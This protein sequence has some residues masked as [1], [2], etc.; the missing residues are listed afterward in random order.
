M[1]WRALL[2][3]LFFLLNNGIII[4]EGIP[5]SQSG[6]IRSD[7][8]PEIT[9]D[10]NMQLMGEGV[11]QFFSD[12][13]SGQLEYVTSFL[14]NDFLDIIVEDGYAFCAVTYGL[15][16]LD[17]AGGLPFDTLS[18]LYLPSRYG[19][20]GDIEKNGDILYFSRYYDGVYLVDVSN[21]EEPQILSQYPARFRITYSFAEDNLLF[22][23]DEDSSLTILDVTDPSQPELLSTI[24]NLGRVKRVCANDEIALVA[25]GYQLHILKTIDPS[26]PELITSYE[27][28]GGKYAT[29]V[30]LDGNIAY[31]SHGVYLPGIAMLILDI[32]NPSNPELISIYEPSDLDVWDIDMVLQ[33]TIIFF[34]SDIVDVRD[35]RTPHFIYQYRN[36]TGTGID[37]YDERIYVSRHTLINV[38]DLGP[39]QDTPEM[40]NSLYVGCHFLSGYPRS[41]LDGD[42]II[43]DSLIY[44]SAS[45][46]GILSVNVNDVENP[47]IIGCLE[48]QYYKELFDIQ[49]DI[50]YADKYIIDINNPA[51]MKVVGVFSDLPFLS[52]VID[53]YIYDSFAF[54]VIDDNLNEDGL[55]L[56][57]V[58]D[59]TT[60]I[61]IS[62]YEASSSEEKSVIV[63]DTIAYLTTGS[64]LHI[65]DYSNAATPQLISIYGDSPYASLA[66]S[67]S[68]AYLATHKKFE[69]VDISDPA[70]PIQLGIL[71]PPTY[72]YLGT[73]R[74]IALSGNYA[75][76][77]TRYT[78][79]QAIDISN[80]LNPFLAETYRTPSE[81]SHDICIRDN[82]IY[83]AD[84]YGLMVLN[85]ISKI[86]YLC[87][88]INADGTVNV[89]DAVNLMSYIFTHGPAPEPIERGELNC[90][91]EINVSDIIHLINFIFTKGNGPCDTDGD[92]IPDC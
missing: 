86:D 6:N 80:P 24:K 29:N 7:E 84:V 37:V 20:T 44:V 17:V 61:F 32:S 9:V 55:Y 8:N 88:D 28:P 45:G 51:D 59:P 39:L 72:P 47:K 43:H 33:D 52:D 10:P 82:L 50:L 75:Y 11:Q 15:I 31:V 49:N 77:A 81:G 41:V 66:I 46:Q 38:Y 69:V 63:I 70:L 22:M 4:A 48:Y 68:I 92:G 27:L 87:G 2:M 74:G 16:I 18:A 57:D 53:I 78:S 13:K 67:D 1:F 79:L 91:N 73:P 42:P 12:E 40:G 23:V 83:L 34:G 62:R 76:L 64:G 71:E 35:P 89:T 5:E 21:L 30:I 25:A 26:H 85:T 65:I 60:P 14:W 58:N 19:R 3:V 56:Y 36:A 90:D 54:L